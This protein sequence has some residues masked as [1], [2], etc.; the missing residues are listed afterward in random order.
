MWWVALAAVLWCL[1]ASSNHFASSGLSL[2]MFLN[3]RL[4][5]SK[6]EMVVWEKSLPYILPMARPTSPWVYPSLIR[7]CLN[8][9]ENRSNSSRSVFSS[10]GKSRRFGS[11]REGLDERPP[12]DEPDENPM[13]WC[14][15]RPESEAML[16]SLWGEVR[17]ALGGG[18]GV[19]GNLWTKDFSC[20]WCIWGRLAYAAC[21]CNGRKDEN[22]KLILNG[23]FF[24]VPQNKR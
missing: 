13:P 19:G 3:E 20:D 16:D 11:E 23:N 8:N 21:N 6:R 17:T 22:V 1:S 18:R 9:F 15:E 2:H 14:S 7:F 24:Y 4:R 5:A 12:L 10:G